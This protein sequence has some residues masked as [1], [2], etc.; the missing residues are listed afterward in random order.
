MFPRV[1]VHS[2]MGACDGV[3]HVLSPVI[4][5]LC[6][7]R[8]PKRLA[9]MTL[10]YF[11]ERDGRLLCIERATPPQRKTLFP[12]FMWQAVKIK[13]MGTSVGNSEIPPS[14]SLL[15]MPVVDFE[16]CVFVVLQS[17]QR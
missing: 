4:L 1:T 15:Y 11:K 17:V 14:T 3:S 2:G 16:L 5:Y 6:R 10:T 13:N 9:V 7:K 12:V 8:L